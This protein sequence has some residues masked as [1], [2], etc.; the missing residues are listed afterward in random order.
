VR[1]KFG[2]LICE[3]EPREKREKKPAGK[4]FLRGWTALIPLCQDPDGSDKKR[5]RKKR[6]LRGIRDKSS[7]LLEI[8]LR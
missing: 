5:I 8:N 2:N 7:K 4:K 1:G 6:D 3:S